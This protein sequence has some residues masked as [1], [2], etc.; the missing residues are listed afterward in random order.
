MRAPG[1]VYV[2]VNPREPSLVRVGKSPSSP[3]DRAHSAKLQLRDAAYFSDCSV[4]E[5][6][7]HDYLENFHTDEDPEVFEVPVEV[8]LKA[9]TLAMERHVGTRA[10]VRVSTALY[11]APAT[12]DAPERLLEQA[13][14]CKASGDTESAIRHYQQAARLGE[15]AAFLALAEL[16]PDETRAVEWL[17][18]GTRHESRECWGALADRCP[19]AKYFRPYFRGLDTK[20]LKSE[21]KQAVVRRL[22]LYLQLNLETED[23]RIIEPVV[24][25]LADRELTRGW[26][27]VLE[28]GNGGG[29]LKWVI[30]L[31]LAGTIGVAVPYYLHSNAQTEAVAEPEAGEAKPEETRP[32]PTRKSRAARPK[33]SAR[34]QAPVAPEAAPAAQ[35]SSKPLD[36]LHKPD[37]AVTAPK[38]AA[39]PEHPSPPPITGEELREQFNWSKEKATDAFKDSIV[40]ITDVV[41]KVGKHDVSFKKIKCKFEASPPA[42]LQPGATATVEGLLRGKGRWTG[43]ITLEQCRVL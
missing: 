12:L 21:Q 25:E 20:G 10:T 34:A 39:L 32:A 3:E 22:R 30:A 19:E 18:E 23:R 24:K 17:K 33:E 36:S 14:Q 4:A 41:T 7:V 37:S 38:V 8:A 11:D 29:A 31:G 15:S 27:R 6:F 9:L 28:G 40:K 42:Q 43:T 13:A 2:M 26:E 1:F 35:E 5:G 16:S